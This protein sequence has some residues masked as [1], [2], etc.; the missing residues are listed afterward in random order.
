[1]TFEFSEDK[2]CFRRVES[3]KISSHARRDLL[4]GVLNVANCCLEQNRMD[5]K[6]R[7]VSY[8]V[9]KSGDS[10]KEMRSG[11]LREALNTMKIRRPKQNL[12]EHFGRWKIIFKEQI[13]KS[14][15]SK[16]NKSRN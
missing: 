10:R 1:M 7:N 13:P 5:R 15:C 16:E 3:C 6:R 11:Y 2:I 8:Y 14:T 9:H 4:R 12:A